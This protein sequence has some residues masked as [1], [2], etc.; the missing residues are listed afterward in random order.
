MHSCQALN[1]DLGMHDTLREKCAVCGVISR[2][3]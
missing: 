3:M 2:S 1:E